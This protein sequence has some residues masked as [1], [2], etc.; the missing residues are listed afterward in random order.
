MTK[1]ESNQNKTATRLVIKKKKKKRR[2]K[3]RSVIPTRP[4]K[5]N[6]IK[7]SKDKSTNTGSLVQKFHINTRK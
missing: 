3:I 6:D 7:G 2:E 4:K 5:S 1:S